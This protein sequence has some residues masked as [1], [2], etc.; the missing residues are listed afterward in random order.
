MRFVLV[1]T[2]LLALCSALNLPGVPLSFTEDDEVLSL[3]SDEVAHKF[4]K[5]LKAYLKTGVEST[6][7]QQITKQLA[8]THT[9]KEI[10]TRNIADL[11]A[12]DQFVVCTTCRAT[13]SVLGD[14]FRDPEGELS[15]P[16]ADQ[17]AKKVMLDVC[18]RLNLQTREVCAGLFDLN[19]PIL[20]Y[21]IHNTVADTRSLCGILPISFCKVK[22]TQFN[23]TLKIDGSAAAVDGPKSN[24]PAKSDADLKIVQLTDIHY[25]PE[26][27]PGSLAVCPE[28]MCCQLSS[29]SGVIEASKQAGYWGDYR[30]CDTPLHLIENAFDHIREVHEKID[31]VYQTGDIVSHIYWATT[32]DGNKDVL[33]RINQLFAEKFAG[34]PVYPTV[35]NHEPHPSN[36]FGAS[37]LPAEFN[38]KWLYEHLWS[39]WSG[40]LPADAEKTVLKGGYYTASPKKGFRVISINSNDCYLYNW[41]VYHDGSVVIEQLQWLHD[42]LLAA[43]KAGE[44][45]HILSHI[46]SGD[47]DCWTVWAREFNR[48]IERYNHIIG[49]IFTGHTHVDELNVH[50]SSKGHAVGVSWNGGSLTT[51][52]NKNPN[53]VVYQVEPKSLQVV[54]YEAWIFDLEKA[55]AQGAVAKL[56]WFKEYSISEFTSNL[57]PAGLDALLDQFAENPKLLEKYWQYKHT[58]ANPRLD[59]GCDKKCLSKTLCRMAVTAYDQKSRCK[60]LKEKL[61]TNLPAVTTAAPTTPAPNT[62]KPTTQ[63][64][65][66]TEEPEGDAA[67]SISCM[68]LTTMVAFLLL[69]RFLY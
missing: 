44:Y 11:R 33:T 27:E 64:P 61:E 48:I 38:V 41:W 56:E 14:M 23:F 35:G 7:L 43:E 52:S 12:A 9:Q 6:V 53:Y 54:D 63:G 47:A 34:I 26:Y 65:I 46:P 30:D 16:T 25:D 58:S 17:I 28:P 3:I 1:F 18:N 59:G 32:K 67:A 66:T 31:Y 36:V 42:T 57:S 69:A 24:I 2:G 19:W 21:T 55:N 15:G 39:L 22:Q 10:F 8:A 62:D 20:N 37:D 4:A 13:V 60:Q 29:A 50:Y 49:G 40:W 68:Q 5:E 51:Y 45:V